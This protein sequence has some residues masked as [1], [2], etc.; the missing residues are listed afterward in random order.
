LRL[1]EVGRP[2]VGQEG[3]PLEDIGEE[4][5]NEELWED[6]PGGG[7]QLDCKNKKLII[8]III[9]S[10]PICL[11]AEAYHNCSLRGST[12]Q[13]TKT[14]VDAYTQTLDRCW[15]FLWKSWRRD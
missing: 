14:D 12:Q 9:N 11:Q 5:W 3:H 8:I 6:R 7:Q 15:G 10:T 1:Q 4:E 13:L 2:S